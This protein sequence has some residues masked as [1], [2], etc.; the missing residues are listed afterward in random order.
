[1][2]TI[3]DNISHVALAV[4]SIS[5]YPYGRTNSCS[6][7]LIESTGQ[8]RSFTLSPARLT[9]ATEPCGSGIF[10]PIFSARMAGG[11]E[12]MFDKLRSNG[13]T[14]EL[15]YGLDEIHQALGKK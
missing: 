10:S 7:C 8:L 1:M 2:A 15:T 4:V 9:T 14:T 12:S 11:W 5:Q 6:G 13:A 3:K